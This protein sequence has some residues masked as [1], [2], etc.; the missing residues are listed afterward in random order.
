M[1]GFI[2]EGGG[3]EEILRVAPKTGAKFRKDYR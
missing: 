2:E 3:Y 1:R